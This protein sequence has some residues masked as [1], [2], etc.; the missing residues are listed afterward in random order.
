MPE[1]IAPEQR[2]HL[3]EFA[4][5]R[6]KAMVARDKGALGLIVVSG[7]NTQVKE[8]LVKLKFESTLAGTSIAVISVTD[9]VAEQLLS[10][11][12]KSLKAL[13]TALDGGEPEPGFDLTGVRLSADIR[14]RQEKRTGRNVLARLNAGEG[15]GTS[16]VVIGAHIDHI[17]RGAGMNSLAGGDDAGKIHYGADDNASGVSALLEIAQYLADQKRQRRLKLKRDLLFAAWSGEEMGLLGS[18]RFVKQFGAKGDDAKGLSPAVTAYLNMDMVGR[19]DKELYLLGVGSSSIWPGEIERRNAPIGLSIHTQNDTFL[20]TDATSFYL[21]GVPIL[22]AFTGAT[23][24]YNTPRDTADIINY[25]GLVKITRLMSLITRSLGMRAEA[26]DYIESE[27]PTTKAS[28]ANLRAFLGAIPDYADSDTQGGR[29]NGVSKGAPAEKAGILPGDIIME[30]AGRKIENIY[31]YTHALNALKVGQE[32]E[33]IVK[34]DG[35]LKTLK[36]A[37]VAR[38]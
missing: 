13:Q 8:Q 30:L 5:L 3:S 10:G 26:P 25:E 4:T 23:S 12:G 7:P 27:K 16:V 29:I 31:D 37:P 22:S 20:P 18:N 11:S 35:A 21:N 9:A 36:I 15:P 14:L 1:N 34:R 2:Q 38:E 32:V 17:G 28:R 19:L 24:E 33:I 6:Y